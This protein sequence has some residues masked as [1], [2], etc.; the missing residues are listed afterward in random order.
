MKGWLRKL[1]RIS[2]RKTSSRPDE[3]VLADGHGQLLLLAV[4]TDVPTTFLR[5]WGADGGRIP[6]M[7]RLLRILWRIKTRRHESTQVV[8]HSRLC[9]EIV[10]HP[11]PCRRS[12]QPFLSWGWLEILRSFR[13]GG[14]SVPKLDSAFLSSCLLHCAPRGHECVRIAPEDKRTWTF[15]S[16]SHRTARK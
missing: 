15:T 10:S 1:C 9:V 12:I 8:L 7:T 16:L 11:H 2:C 4:T 14:C 3:A 6:T 13:G 5:T